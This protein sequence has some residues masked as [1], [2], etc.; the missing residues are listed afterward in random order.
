MLEGKVLILEGLE[1]PDTRRASAISVKE[2]TALTHEVGD[3]FSAI[4]ACLSYTEQYERSR[5]EHVGGKLTMR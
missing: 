3:L 1:A 4:S 2:V 5:G